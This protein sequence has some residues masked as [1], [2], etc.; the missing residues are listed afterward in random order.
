MPSKSKKLTEEQAAILTA[1]TGV[2]CGS[3]SKFHEYAE[4]VVGRPIWTH[5]MGDPNT[6]EEIK[7]ASKP[8]FLAITEI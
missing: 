8:D 2:L 7:A 1:Y 5:E 3:F 6:A 4:R